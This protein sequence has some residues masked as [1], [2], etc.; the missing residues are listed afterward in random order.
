MQRQA[1]SICLLEQEL[2]FKE[3]D[4]HDT[5]IRKKNLVVPTISTSYSRCEIVCSRMRNTE[6]LLIAGNETRQ[7]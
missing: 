6:G 3:Y 7:F 5:K 2:D 4:V 1:T